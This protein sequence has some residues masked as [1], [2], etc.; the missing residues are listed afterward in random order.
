[1][2]DQSE[3]LTVRSAHRLTVMGNLTSWAR[4]SSAIASN[5]E[6]FA[7]YEILGIPVF[8]MIRQTD[9]LPVLGPPYSDRERLNLLYSRVIRKT[10]NITG[11]W[12]QR[13]IGSSGPLGEEPLAGGSLGT[14]SQGAGGI[15]TNAAYTA[16]PTFWLPGLTFMPDVRHFRDRCLETAQKQSCAKVRA[17]NNERMNSIIFYYKRRRPLSEEV[18]AS[19]AC[20]VR[21]NMHSSNEDK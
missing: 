13:P 7:R 8:K 15:I 4:M 17:K 1:M 6:T 11:R 16:M 9:F 5:A 10:R 14:R 3:S 20:E 12:Q 2:Y 19:F 21:P 18:V